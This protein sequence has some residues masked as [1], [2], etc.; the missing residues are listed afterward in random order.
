MSYVVR[1]LVRQLVYT[2]FV[3][4]NCASFNLHWSQ[5]LVKHQNISKYYENDCSFNLAKLQ[6]QIFSYQ[7]IIIF[8]WWGVLCIFFQEPFHTNSE[9]LPASS[10]AFECLCFND[11]NKY[12]KN[13]VLNLVYRPSSVDHK[14]LENYFKS[15]LSLSIEIGNLTQRCNFN[16]RF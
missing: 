1:Q 11:K 8:T 9:D 13:I 12:F 5:S 7:D 6:I 16:C 15:S 2:R 14:E 3:S 4:N 10:K